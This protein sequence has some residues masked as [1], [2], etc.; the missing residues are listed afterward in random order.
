MATGDFGSTG[1]KRL[2]GSY[3]VSVVPTISSRTAGSQ[4]AWL[5]VG[6]WQLAGAAPLRTSLPTITNVLILASYLTSIVHLSNS[7]I[8][9]YPHTT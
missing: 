9:I 2:E 4:V 7:C 8:G 5:A 3:C 6:S 1:A